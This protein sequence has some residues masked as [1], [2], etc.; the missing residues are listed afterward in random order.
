MSAARRP[1]PEFAEV[2]AAIEAEYADDILAKNEAP[3]QEGATVQ[4]AHPL[5]IL[6]IL[7]NQGFDSLIDITAT[8]CGELEREWDFEVIYMLRRGVE[9]LRFRLNVAV[10]GRKSPKL[11]TSTEL[12]PAAAWPEREVA[13][14]FGITFKE[15]PDP[16]RLFLPDGF[17]GKPLRKEYAATGEEERDKFPELGV[18]TNGSEA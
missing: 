11:P 18:E 12:Y 17:D 15:H 7:R 9:G 10:I 4:S 13:E 16:R 6:T 3:G 1:R 5:Q 8:D 14:M 2:F